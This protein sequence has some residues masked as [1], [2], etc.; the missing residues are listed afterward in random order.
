MNPYQLA[1]KALNP[2]MTQRERAAHL[3]RQR[4]IEMRV[5]RWKQTLQR[6]L[7]DPQPPAP[8]LISGYPESE[9]KMVA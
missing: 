9:W 2:A 7:R 5:E 3:A 1:G 8:R 6:Q 4:R